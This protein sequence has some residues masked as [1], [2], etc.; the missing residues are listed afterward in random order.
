MRIFLPAVYI[1]ITLVG[2]ILI[3][4]GIAFIIMGIIEKDE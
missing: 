4:I 1:D 3:I 2:V